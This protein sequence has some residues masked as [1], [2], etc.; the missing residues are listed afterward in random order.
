MRIKLLPMLRLAQSMKP[1]DPVAAI[2]DAVAVGGE[3]D[4]VSI[5]ANV[6]ENGQS[7]NIEIGEGILKAIGAVIREQQNAQMRQLQRGGQF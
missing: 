3:N 4:Y 2:I 5:V 1:T 7:S 6:I